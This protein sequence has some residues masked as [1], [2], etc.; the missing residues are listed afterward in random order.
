MK[1]KEDIKILL[2]MVWTVI[3]LFGAASIVLLIAINFPRFTFWFYSFPMAILN[4]VITFA[5]IALVG[6]YIVEYFNKRKK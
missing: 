1:N 5:V 6:W 4:L 2:K 3:G